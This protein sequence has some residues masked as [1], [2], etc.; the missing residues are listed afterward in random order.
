MS[1][2]FLLMDCGSPRASIPNSTS[3]SRAGGSIRKRI[4][5]LQ[6]E[7]AVETTADGRLRVT[8]AGFPCSTPWSTISRREWT[9]CSLHVMRGLVAP[10][11]PEPPKRLGRGIDD[12]APSA[13]PA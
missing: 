10:H 2:E 1:D 13:I 4:A 12:L 7:G 8:L 9:D 5:I 6:D 11:V 3:S